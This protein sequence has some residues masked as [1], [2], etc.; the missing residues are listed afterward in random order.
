MDR[1]VC[2]GRL[3]KRIE[4][5]YPKAGRG[6]RRIRFGR[7][8]GSTSVQRFYNLSDPGVEV[9]LYEVE[10][11]RWFVGLRLAGAPPDEAPPAAT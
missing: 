1:L 10:S 2:W 3:E 11:V 4:P 7:C 6:R 5:F 9:L 8:C